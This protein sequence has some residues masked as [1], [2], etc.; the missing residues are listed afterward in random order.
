MNELTEIKNYICEIRNQKVILDR[1]LAA[2]YKVP[3]KALNQ[4]VKRN[5]N[6]FP[7]DFM[8]QLNKE[9]MN[10]WRSQFVTS[11]S[12]KMGMRRLPYAFTEQGVAMLSSVLHS[13]TAIAVNIGIM[14]AF[15]AV[16]QSIE[17]IPATTHRLTAL[18]QNFTRLKEELEEIFSDYNDI[19]E[20]TRMQLELINQSL[21]ELQSDK[22][23]RNKRRP[24]IGFV[25]DSEK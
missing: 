14:R 3:T 4:A 19:N 2:L 9:E 7:P 25:I 21:A 17:Q 5:I 13:E 18:E 1:D 16:R 11:N 12:I 24:K 15:V 10:N 20:D 8:F 6:R 23:I 22:K